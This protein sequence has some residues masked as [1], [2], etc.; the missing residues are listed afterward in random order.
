MAPA[1]LHA[2]LT[3]DGAA[4]ARSPSSP[5][6]AASARCASRSTGRPMPTPI[7]FTRRRPARLDGKLEADDGKIAAGMLGLDRVVAVNAG[8]GALTLKASGQAGGDMKI[9]GKLSAGGL[10]ASASGTARLFADTPSAA[11]TCNDHA[12]PMRRRYVAAYAARLPVTFAGNVGLTSQRLALSDINAK[13]AGA[14][15]RGKLALRWLRRAACKARSTPTISMR[16]AWSPRPS[17]C[18]R[19]Q[20]RNGLVLV[21]RTV[22]RAV[23]SAIMPAQIALQG[24]ARRFAAAADGARISRN[25]A[26]RQQRIAFDD[27]TGRRRRRAS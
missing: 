23:C 24:A 5:S 6:T 1:K 17:A 15:L 16:R 26:F 8:P 9:D 27:M 2:Q 10:E 14:A 4:P 25:F 13:V 22:R 12:A 3:I 20:R 18:R 7:A 19:R 21:E 11:L